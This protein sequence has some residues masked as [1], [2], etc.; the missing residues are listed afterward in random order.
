MIYYIKLLLYFKGLLIYV[1][2]CIGL[3][4]VYIINL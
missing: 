4:F 2:V 3:L 1:D